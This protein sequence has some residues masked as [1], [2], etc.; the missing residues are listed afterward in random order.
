MNLAPSESVRES[1]RV[2]PAR[3]AGSGR[4]GFTLL[5]MMITVGILLVLMG[6]LLVGLNVILGN[7]QRKQTELILKRAQSLT[8]EL[9]NSKE[10]RASFYQRVLY[11]SMIEGTDPAIPN[12]N[13]QQNA[14][15]S[16]AA[17]YRT[18]LITEFLLS[19]P[20]NR[21][22]AE[23]LNPR[24]AGD[25]PDLVG[26]PIMKILNTSDPALPVRTPPPNDRTNGQLLANV[27][28]DAW[29]NPIVFVA[30]GFET[31]SATGAPVP[32]ASLGG[33]TGLKS[34][35]TG[36]N[37]NSNNASGPTRFT[38]AD[39]RPFWF[40]AGPDGNY[41]THDDNVYSFNQ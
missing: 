2:S 18:V 3:I 25:V 41:E 15:N 20:A 13:G 26:E 39:R 27:L 22:A 11:R 8:A 36:G 14:G 6:V 16:R 28:V 37:V 30:D 38:A 34:T 23:K 35:I 33:L 5:E 21:T 10:A 24:S 9:G 40:S 19:I 12:A 29:G 7:N 17:V 32:Q 4:R 31:V 1:V